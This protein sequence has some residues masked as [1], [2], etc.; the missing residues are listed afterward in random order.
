MHWL[1]Y[2][3]SFDTVS[4]IHHWP[5][6]LPSIVLPFLQ[7]GT[8]FNCCW[9]NIRHHRTP[10]I[11]GWYK[12]SFTI[13]QL[14]IMDLHV[15]WLRFVPW[16]LFWGL[17]WPSLL[18]SFILLRLC[19]PNR[20]MSTCRVGIFIF[21][22]FTKVNRFYSLELNRSYHS[23]QRTLGIYHLVSTSRLFLGRMSHRIQQ[24][25]RF[26]LGPFRQ[27]LAVVEHP[28]AYIHQVRRRIHILTW[29][30]W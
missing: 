11:T 16:T 25:I 28:L 1:R 3:N 14:Y 29:L 18:V 12:C 21:S 20:T 7:L 19:R 26:Q 30:R 13:K 5:T 22:S 15:G 24:R 23:R 9:S 2:R 6:C 27:V 8:K 17:H 4:F 10:R